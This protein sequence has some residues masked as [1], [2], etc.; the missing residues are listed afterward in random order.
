MFT[1]SGPIKESCKY[2]MET[3]FEANADTKIGSA[4]APSFGQ[5]Y[6]SEGR[7]C[8]Y[9]SFMSIPRPQK[10]TLFK[11]VRSSVGYIALYLQTIEFIQN[12][13]RKRNTGW[14][15]MFRE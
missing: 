3:Q 13:K 9:L 6:S 5:V 8:G 15:K 14:M 10:Q 11:K 7:W 12:Q 4:A 1:G 2:S